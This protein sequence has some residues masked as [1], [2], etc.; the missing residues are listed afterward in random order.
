MKTSP[1]FY[2]LFPTLVATALAV[3]S[4]QAVVIASYTFE[5][6]ANRLSS[7]DTELNTTASNLSISSIP[8]LEIN[9]QHTDRES[10]AHSLTFDLPVSGFAVVGSYGDIKSGSNNLA[11]AL[12]NNQY[13]GF[14]I[15]LGTATTIDLTSFSFATDITSGTA[16]KNYWLLADVIGGTFDAADQI[17]SGS[18]SNNESKVIT[19]FSTSSFSS[20]TEFRLYF[21]TGASTASHGFAIDDITLEAT[22]T[23]IPEPSAALL[24]GIGTLL[25]LRRRR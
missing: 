2:A 17:G 3:S 5:T 18:F 20:N 12:T 15:T 22:V 21:D 7:S 4:A 25:L 1:K 24:G 19:T 23:P 6:A 10:T 9:S 8:G 11:G 14:T 13:I 16:A